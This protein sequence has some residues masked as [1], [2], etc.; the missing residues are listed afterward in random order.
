VLAVPYLACLEIAE[1]DVFLHSV[2]LTETGVQTKS[3]SAFLEEGMTDVT[4]EAVGGS[5]PVV[6]VATRD[7]PSKRLLLLDVNGFTLYSRQ[8]PAASKLYIAPY[9]NSNI[10]LQA[11]YIEGVSIIM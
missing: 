1:H 8:L 10:I 4:L 11:Q 6:A 5:Q 9:E 7:G 2:T 3:L